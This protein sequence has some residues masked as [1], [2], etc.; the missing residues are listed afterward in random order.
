MHIT[1]PTVIIFMDEQKDVWSYMCLLCG[2]PILLV[3]NHRGSIQQTDDLLALYKCQNKVGN[4]T[5]ASNTARQL[6]SLSSQVYNLNKHI[7]HIC[8]SRTL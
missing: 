6:L 7:R 2:D 8:Q 5:E 4:Y 3:S 1:V